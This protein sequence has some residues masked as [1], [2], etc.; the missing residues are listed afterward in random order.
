MTYR[1]HHQCHGKGNGNFFQTSPYWTYPGHPSTIDAT[2][3]GTKNDDIDTYKGHDIIFGGRGDDLIEPGPV[4]DLFFGVRGCDTMTGGRGNDTFVLHYECRACDTITDFQHGGAEA[5]SLDI[6][7]ILRGY[8]PLSDAI[9]DFVRFTSRGDDTIVKINAD[10]R[11]CYF[12]KVATLEN[13]DLSF[14]NA[15]DLINDGSLIA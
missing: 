11:D 3:L 10:G 1:S 8:D 15:Q 2:Q 9:A 14:V 13:I 12:H 7:D 6:S 4:N 5:D